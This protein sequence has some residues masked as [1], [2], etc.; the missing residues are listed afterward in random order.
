KDRELM[1]IYQSE[2]IILNTLKFKDYDQILTL[3]CKE[4]GLIKLFVKGAYR[5]KEG[6]GTLTAPLIQAEFLYIK[7]KSQLYL[8]K[9]LSVINFH[10]Q[11]RE[12]LQN[13]NAACEIAKI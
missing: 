12:R 5:N 6:R 9:D 3:F 4:E 1:K 10:R 11:L 8:C 7:Q 13:L 2:G